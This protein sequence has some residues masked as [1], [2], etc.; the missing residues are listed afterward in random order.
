MP[1]VSRIVIIGVGL[2][3]GSLGLAAKK[4]QL[5]ENVIGIDHNKERLQTALQLGV[6]DEGMSTLSSLPS[7][8]L[9]V[10]ATPV[11][12]VSDYVRQAAAAVR[13]NDRNV[14]ITDV[15]STKELICSQLEQTVLP[16][17]CRFIGSHPI[18]GKE[19]SGVEYADA[20]LFV[21]HLAVITPTPSTHDQDFALL[22]QFWRALGA[23]TATMSPAEHDRTLARTS[24]L[25]HLLSALLASRL[26]SQDAPYTGSGYYSVTRLASG[27][28]ELWRDIVAHNAEAILE[29][30]HDYEDA[31]QD[32]QQAIKRSDWNAVVQF[33]ERAKKNRDSL[34]G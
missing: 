5:T 4:R 25:P 7:T 8:E 28:P 16:N 33:F 19:L 18:A 23:L 20:D 3:G 11:S 29:A 6:I 24:H 30:L 27:Q 31:L 2:I 13:T 22:D 14:L 26:Q 10:V 21:N 17:G 12:L 15:G 34:N 32:L 9:I 1:L